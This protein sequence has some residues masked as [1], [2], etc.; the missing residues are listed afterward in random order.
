MV[1]QAGDFLDPTYPLLASAFR[2]ALE[3]SEMAKKGRLRTTDGYVL[4]N[5]RTST[6]LFMP[7]RKCS[8][9]WPPPH[10]AGTVRR[11]GNN[12]AGDED[13]NAQST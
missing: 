2:S 1:R 4:T 8:T 7:L 11:V 12:G 9:S 5:Q 6:Q 3:F 13:R 10:H